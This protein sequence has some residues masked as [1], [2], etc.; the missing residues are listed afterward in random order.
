MTKRV[1]HYQSRVSAIL[2]SSW[3]NV[4]WDYSD[5]KSPNKKL[6]EP[7]LQAQKSSFQRN[8][9]SAKISNNEEI[10]AIY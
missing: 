8:K 5:L 1:S 3:V 7:K 6:L 9:R 4:K 10:M 2:Q